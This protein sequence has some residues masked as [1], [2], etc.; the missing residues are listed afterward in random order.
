MTRRHALL[1]VAS[2]LAMI[3]C[4]RSR[5]EPLG[6]V[7][8][9]IDTLRA[10]RLGLYGYGPPTSPRVDALASESTVFDAAVPTCPATAPSVASFLTGLYRARTA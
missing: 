7:L 6:V 1:G 10:D 4:G 5:P 9:T 2:L 3:G 8:V